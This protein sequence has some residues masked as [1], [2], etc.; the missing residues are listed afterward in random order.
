[1]AIGLGAAL[2]GSAIIGGGA[3]VLGGKSAAK[4]QD[5][6]TQAN[7]A[8]QTNIYNSNK[9]TLD[10]YI[11]RGNYAGTQ[12]SALLSGGQGATDAFNQFKAGTGYQ[13][14]LNEALG[15]VNSNAYAR[16]AGSSGA[17][18]K[19]LQDRAGQVATGTFGQYAGLLGNQQ[20]VGLSAASA[21]A[22]VGQGYANNVSANNNAN[23]NAQGNAALNTAGQINGLLGN[24][25]QYAAYNKGLNSSYGGNFGGQGIY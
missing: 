12:L 10:P 2:I 24:L 9:G 17:T 7:N 8:L 18:L 22:G 16:G 14:T 23:A 21:L 5:K 11:Q 4:S 1:M 20:G 13:T 25:T 15:S 19:A 3:S 6:A